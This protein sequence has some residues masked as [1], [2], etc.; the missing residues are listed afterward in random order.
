MTF[1]GGD[2]VDVGNVSGY[3][4]GLISAGESPT[5]GLD[6]F[7]SDGGEIQTSRWFQLFGQVSNTL[8]DSPQALGLDPFSLPGP[9]D[10]DT[11][12][13][14]RGSGFATQVSMQVYDRDSD[15]FLS[16]QSTYITD[17]PHTPEEA[18]DWMLA[19]FDPENTGSD[20]NQVAM[21]AV[22]TNVWTITPLDS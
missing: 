3:I 7:R 12:S 6:I 15:T 14:Q 18:Q 11:W 2:G 4:K 19:N 22:A 10:Y 16:L 8:A 9:S 5:A 17:E 1:D 21:G 13:L 20:F